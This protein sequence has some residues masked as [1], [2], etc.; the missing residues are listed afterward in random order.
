M[1]KI[2]K[3]ERI[4]LLAIV[5]EGCEIAL[6]GLCSVD[7]RPASSDERVASRCVRRV[8]MFVRVSRI[9]RPAHCSVFSSNVVG[10]KKE[11]YIKGQ[12]ERVKG[13]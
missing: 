1:L 3:T 11:W 9:D 6:L 4:F 12:T 13:V 5:L 8:A 7:R 2:M 10:I